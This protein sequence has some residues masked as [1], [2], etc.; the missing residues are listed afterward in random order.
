MRFSISSQQIIFNKSRG[1][2]AKEAKS[3][4]KQ[5][6]QMIIDTIYLCHP[7]L[8]ESLLNSIEKVQESH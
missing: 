8:I 3:A 6:L 4:I 7:I 5:D 2:K 1:K